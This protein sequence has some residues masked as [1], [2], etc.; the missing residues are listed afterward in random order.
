[1]VGAVVCIRLICVL[2]FKSNCLI[3]ETKN[4]QTTCKLYF[5]TR[6]PLFL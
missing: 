6:K 4:L 2:I 5:G 3:N 1:M